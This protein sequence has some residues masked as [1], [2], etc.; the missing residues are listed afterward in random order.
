VYFSYACASLIKEFLRFMTIFHLLLMLCSNAFSL[1]ITI[2][3]CGSYNQPNCTT[4][5]LTSYYS[6]LTSLTPTTPVRGK[7]VRVSRGDIDESSCKIRTSVAGTVV[8]YNE[9]TF[10]ALLGCNTDPIGTQSALAR[11]LVNAGAIGVVM[12][13]VETVCTEIIFHI[14]KFLKV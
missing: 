12:P 14:L 1:S 7:L 2:E 11:V 5:T 8:V 3:Q 13:A 9:T 4:I 6:T 10:P